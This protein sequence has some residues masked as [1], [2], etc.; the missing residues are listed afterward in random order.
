MEII[1]LIILI[2]V[3]G[4]F[5]KSV[6]ANTVIIID[7]NTHYL[8][9]KK[10][11][12]YFFNPA[13][14]KITTRISTYHLHKSYVENFE[15]HDG[16]LVRVAFSVEYHTENLEDVLAALASARRSIDDVMNGSIYWGVN[17]LSLSDFINTPVVLT[18][19]TKPKLLSE[20]NELK[21]KIDNFQILNIS[22]LPSG[23]NIT[24]FKPHLSSHS[25]GPIRFN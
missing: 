15:T 1:V 9:T 8:K 24:P 4:N 13:T 21:I 7:R 14:D 11:G 10:R 17:N 5:I 22:V 25:T 16:K 6:P 18:T 20:A 12:L 23:I 19:E 2:F 3:L